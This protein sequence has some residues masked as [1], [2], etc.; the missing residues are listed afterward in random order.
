ME[1]V[2]GG[3]NSDEVTGGGLEKWGQRT[4]IG[5]SKRGPLVMIQFNLNGEEDGIQLVKS[6][7]C[8]AQRLVHV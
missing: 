3:S 8:Y 7:V 5:L 2:Q 1:G 6:P 4:W